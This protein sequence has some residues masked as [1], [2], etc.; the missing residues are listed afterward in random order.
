MGRQVAHSWLAGRASSSGDARGAFTLLE[1]VA[2]ITL[3][4]ILAAAAAGAFRPESVGDLDGSVTARR[5]AW[6]LQQA[7]RS[8]ISSGDNHVLVCQASGG[9]ITGFTL[10][11]RLPDS[12]LTPV[13][14]PQ[15]IPDFVT[16]TA[17]S[18]A[19]EFAFE[20]EALAGYTFTITSPHKSWTVTVAQAT[21]NVRIQ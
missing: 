6:N 10:Q 4:G 13:D 3:L 11:R 7:R 16:V 5:I 15:T 18:L 14:A 1:M 19:P 12:S 9:N 21:G 2:V 17:S 8:A 20:G